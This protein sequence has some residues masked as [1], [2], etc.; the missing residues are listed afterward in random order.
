M[1][2]ILKLNVRFSYISPQSRLKFVALDP[3]T[4]KKLENIGI[5]DET[6]TVS[7]PPPAAIVPHDI[8]MAVGLAC[9]IY[10]KPIKYSF[11]SPAKHNRGERVTG[12]RL[13]LD[14]LT[15]ADQGSINS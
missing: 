3:E 5:T 15:R 11:K 4:I 9:T 7:L 12:Y 6:F 10:V 8:Y 1:A 2:Q 14:Q 13:I